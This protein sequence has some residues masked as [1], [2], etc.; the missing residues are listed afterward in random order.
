MTQNYA[1]HSSK[2][3]KSWSKNNMRFSI[4]VYIPE[5]NMDF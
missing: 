3:E 4:Q 2:V 1:V 5:E